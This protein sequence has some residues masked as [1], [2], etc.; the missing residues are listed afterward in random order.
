MRQSLRLVLKVK[1]F[2][3]FTAIHNSKIWL[4]AKLL[5]SINSL[6][7][8]AYELLDETPFLRMYIHLLPFEIWIL[9]KSCGGS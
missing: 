6:F 7:L 3:I 9:Q 5:I 1:P 8:T 4:A 2:K